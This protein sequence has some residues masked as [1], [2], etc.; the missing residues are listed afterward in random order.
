MRKIHVL[1][2]LLVLSSVFALSCTKDDKSGSGSSAD[3]I[4]QILEERGNYSQF[5]KALELSGYDKLVGGGG[6]VT[7]FAPDD[8]AF[9]VFLSKKYSARDVSEVPAEELSVLMGYHLIQFAYEPNDFLAFSTSASTDTGEGG[10]GSSFKYKTYGKSPVK[11]IKDPITSRKVNVYSREKFLPVFSSK[12]FQTRKLADPEKDYRRF[13]PDVDWNGTDSQLYAG[14]ALVEERGIQAVNGFLYIVSKVLEPA[15]T[16]YD[17]LSEDDMAE[18]S[19][20][21]EMIDRTNQYTYDATVTRNYSSS[22]D[23]LYY[24]YNWTAPSKTSEIP[25]LASEWTYHNENGVVFENDT[26]LTNICF[27]PKNDVLEPYLKDYFKEYG[28]YD[29][30]DFLDV[31]P[32]NAIYHFLRSHIYGLQDILFPSELDAG[33]ISGP[34]GEK[35]YVSSDEVDVKFCS[36]GVIYGMDKVFVPAVYVHLTRPVMESPDFQFYARAFNVKNMYQQ[37]VDE[38]NRFTLF[39]QNDEDLVSGGYTSSVST[40]GKGVYNYKLRGASINETT[41]SA[42]LMSQFMYGEL[43]SIAGEEMQRYFVC[44]DNTTYFYIK[45]QSLYDSSD[46][47]IFTRNITDELNGTVI[48]TT[49]II[50]SRKG[51]FSESG[52]K[53]DFT[54][55]R[56]LMMK[57]EIGNAAGGLINSMAGMK[58]AMVFIPTNDAVLEAEAAGKIPSDV[59]ELA[60]YL[61]YYFVSLSKNKLENFLLPGLGPEGMTASAFSGTY[62]TYSDY[63]VEDDKKNITISWNPDES[64]HMTLTDMYGNSINTVDGRVELRTNAA[65]YPIESC[66]DYRILFQTAE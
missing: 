58:D 30:A 46:E 56:R 27:L 36:N 4:L 33:S 6:L 61:K 66:F 53:A 54:Q 59:K 52:K 42:L 47:E 38:G 16:V 10:D 15:P 60:K 9:S 44:K 62:V 35:Y 34:N 22:G 3:T 57:A 49:R 12:L 11:T 65:V 13:F 2:A 32:D 43:P 48:Q 63:V 25:E 24:F 23:S 26:R 5:I 39:I 8:E 14:D 29:A 19:I 17:R 20:I 41:V 50:P 7:V 37:T 1:A 51:A 18:Y 45:N 21:K 55:F 28:T 31:I 40:T 64:M